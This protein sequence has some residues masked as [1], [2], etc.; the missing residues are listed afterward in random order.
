K[1]C[2]V[3]CKER[4]MTDTNITFDTRV[5]SM[6]CVNDEMV[7]IGTL[8]WFVFA[9]NQD[10]KEMLWQQRLHDAVLSMEVY[11]D[12]DGD[13]S[14]RLFAGLA[15][16]TVA[17]FEALS[18][19]CTSYDLFYLPIG[20]SPVTCLRLLGNKLWCACGNNVSIIHASTLDPKDR[21]TVSANP[22][23]TILSLVPGLPGVWISVRGSSVL[24]LWDKET[25]SCRMLYDTRTG[26]FPNLRK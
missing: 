17:I 13:K 1:I 11:Q 25:L 3:D 8:S 4:T 14:Q 23:D 2:I 7:L 19:S 21:F 6:V 9:Y 12:D 22:Y 5:M 18:P 16:G 10:T 26:R 24:E 20:Q 15:D